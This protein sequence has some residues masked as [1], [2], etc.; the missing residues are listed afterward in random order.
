MVSLPRCFSVSHFPLQMDTPTYCRSLAHSHAVFSVFQVTFADEEGHGT[1]VT[2]EFYSLVSA[3]LQRRDLGM[4]MCDDTDH[5][6]PMKKAKPPP[7]SQSTDIAIAAHGRG[8][9]SSST[10][11]GARTTDTNPQYV[12]RES[13]TSS[14]RSCPLLLPPVCALLRLAAPCCACLMP[15]PFRRTLPGPAAS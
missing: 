12:H 4:W 9:E 6:A 13:G 14:T 8:A 5:S 10:R 11:D 1:G 15:T 7:V 2:S 3:A